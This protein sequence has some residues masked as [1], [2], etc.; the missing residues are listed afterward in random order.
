MKS[1]YLALLG[2]L[3][4]LAVGMVVK[5]D[6]APATAAADKTIRIKA[7]SNEAV[8]DAQGNTWEAESGFEGGEVAAKDASLA[9]ENT[10]IPEVYRAEHYSM[11]S[12]TRKL[13]NGKYTVKLHF[14]ETYDEIKEAGQRVFSVNVNGTDIKDIDPFKDA[15]GANKALVKT[16]KVD[17]TDGKLTITF[18]ANIQNPEINGIEII[19]ES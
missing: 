3:V 10:K 11:T 16:V 17:V 18:T 13:P 8:K 19:P 9:I 7:G 4:A 1:G 14:A 15:G 12:F 6:P 5:A 2:L